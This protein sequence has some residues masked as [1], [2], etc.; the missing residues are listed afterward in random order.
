MLKDCSISSVN[1]F[2]F[3]FPEICV[4]GWTRFWIFVK[5]S[6]QIEHYSEMIGAEN[7]RTQLVSNYAEMAVGELGLERSSVNLRATLQGHLGL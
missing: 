1:F 5:P 4:A 6:F 7:G 3:Q 2:P